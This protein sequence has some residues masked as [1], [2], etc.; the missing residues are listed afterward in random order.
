MDRVYQ[1]ECHDD[2]YGHWFEIT[3]NVMLNNLKRAELMGF[4]ADIE[5][6]GT[7]YIGIKEDDWDY[8]SDKNLL[9][10]MDKYY[11]C[12]FFDDMYTYPT[13]TEIDVDE[14]KLMMH[15]ILETVSY[16]LNTDTYNLTKAEISDLEDQ[17]NW[18]KDKING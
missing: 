11:E 16:K 13:I 9:H 17:V 15:R 8:F 3:N 14:D 10:G 6:R 5:E 7:C 4:L 18:L 12:K 2:F 1:C